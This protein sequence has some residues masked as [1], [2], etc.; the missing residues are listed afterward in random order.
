VKRAVLLLIAAVMGAG[1]LSF[2]VSSCITQGVA[3]CTTA[4]GTATACA[5]PSESVFTGIWPDGGPPGAAVSEYMTRRCGTLD[6]HGS[7]ERPMRL[8]GRLGLRDPAEL[9]VSGGKP[10][11]PLEL[12]DSYTAVC[13]VQPEET[14]AAVVDQGASGELLLIVEKARGIE[15]HK[16]GQVVTEGSPG[17]NCIAGWLREDEP[18]MVAA[19]C[20]TAIDGL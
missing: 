7:E 13:S 15:A 12:T 10:T 2:G 17:D 11:T 1:S 3:A 5:C 19:A 6:C 9:N 4:D 16:G 20:Q 18:A 8:Y 14:N